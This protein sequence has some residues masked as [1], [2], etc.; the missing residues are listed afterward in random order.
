MQLHAFAEQARGKHIILEQTIHAEKNQ[1]KKQMLIP[2][3]PRHQK[4]RHGGG[5]RPDHG[6]E[7][8]DGSDGREQQRIRHTRDR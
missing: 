4:N 8:E 3:E 1:D 2:A 6:N 5:E 7:L